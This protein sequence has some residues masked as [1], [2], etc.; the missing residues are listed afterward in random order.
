METANVRIHPTVHCEKHG[1]RSKA[2]ICEHLLRGMRQ[3]FFA[4]EDSGNPYPDAWCTQCEQVRIAHGGTS[5]E[6]NEKSEA[7][8]TL[9]LVCGDCYEEIRRLNLLDSE[10]SR[11]Q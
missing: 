6:W 10:S 1:D 2:Y 3:G 4:A 5:G 8:L 11:V 9:K 7:L